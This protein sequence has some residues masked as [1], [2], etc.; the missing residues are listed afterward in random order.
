ML[1]LISAGEER[2]GWELVCMG[3]L[4]ARGSMYF[5]VPVVCV[6]GVRALGHILEEEGQ[7]AEKRE[8]I[9]GWSGGESRGS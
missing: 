8:K 4:C 3:P 9:G 6:R 2:R 1:G 7:R 5:A